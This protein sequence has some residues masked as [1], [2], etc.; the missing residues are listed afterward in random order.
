MSEENLKTIGFVKNST[1]D[2][3]PTAEDRDRVKKIISVEYGDLIT[4]VY[5]KDEKDA[6]E[7]LK[8]S[9]RNQEEYMYELMNCYQ[10][11]LESTEETRHLG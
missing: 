8:R 7:R 2:R 6:R 10:K 4:S 5:N 9:K 11:F 3:F 1:D